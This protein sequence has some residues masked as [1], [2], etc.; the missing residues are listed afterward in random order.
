MFTDLQLKRLRLD[1]VNAFDRA[2]TTAL[3]QSVWF[4]LTRRDSHLLPFSIVA[5]CLSQYQSRHLGIQ[6]IPLT[7]IVGSVNRSQ[8]FNRAFSPL[9]D[10]LRE[11]WVSVLMLAGTQG[12]PP[13][14]VIK[15]GNLYFVEDGHHRISVARW[16]KNSVIEAEVVECPLNQVFEPTVSLESFSAQLKRQQQA[17][18]AVAALCG[19]ALCP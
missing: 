13:V 2:R 6:E 17:R 15:V 7:N 12:W 3:W 11:R 16:L 5:T 1:A 10:S 4:R 18:P 14:R 9:R 8:E 19:H